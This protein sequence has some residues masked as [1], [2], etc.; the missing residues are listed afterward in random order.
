MA[1]VKY[2]NGETQLRAI[3]PLKNAEFAALFGDVPVKKYDGVSKMVGEPLDFV[4]T[5]DAAKR[6]FKHDW[7]PVERIVTYKAN[8]SRHE[9]DARCMNATGRTMNCECACGGKNHGRGCK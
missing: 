1:N 2:F 4:P 3:S 8:P 7:R 9:C 5:W 6:G